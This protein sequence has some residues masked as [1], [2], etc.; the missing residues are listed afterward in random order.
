MH[1]RHVS[2]HKPQR[3]FETIFNIPGMRIQEW[4]KTACRDMHYKRA[5]AHMWCA[6][7]CKTAAAQQAPS[8]PPS[9]LETSTCRN[10]QN[11]VMHVDKSVILEMAV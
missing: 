1:L 10:S 8:A 3:Q 7:S 2:I 6:A 9:L 4:R 11:K 5:A